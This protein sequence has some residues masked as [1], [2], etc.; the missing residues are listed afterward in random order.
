MFRI[1]HGLIVRRRA[2]RLMP[3][4]AVAVMLAIAAPAIAGPRGD[5]TNSFHN[6]LN[7]FKAD[8]FAGLDRPEGHISPFGGT[9]PVLVC[10][11]L[12]VGTWFSILDPTRAGL[13][14]VTAEFRLDG[15]LLN[16]TRTPA[17][18]TPHPE[19]GDGWGITNGVPVIGTLDAGTHT[20]EYSFNDGF[21]ATIGIDSSP[22][23]C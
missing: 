6:E 20:L 18:K 21:V 12:V 7:Q 5:L 3:I 10:D 11:D 9:D 2:H 22:A 16:A 23:H 8:D 4:L 14:E 1:K 17:K 15:E 13:E 19:D